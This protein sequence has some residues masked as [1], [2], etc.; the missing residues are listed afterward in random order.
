[1]ELIVDFAYT[2]RIVVQESNVQMLLPAACLLQMTE[3]QE[4]CCEFLKRQLD[5]SNCL[6]IRA[7]ADT[8]ACRELLRIADKFTQHNFQVSRGN[9]VRMF[10]VYLF[11]S[12]LLLC[13]IFRFMVQVVSALEDQNEEL[14]VKAGCNS[15]TI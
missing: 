4:V 6:G 9:P 2:S 11:E 1:M 13:M 15:D 8:H 14:V 7:F 10:I 5:P 12:I 3:I